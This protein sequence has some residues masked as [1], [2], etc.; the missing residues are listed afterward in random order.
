MSN[1][2]SQ[3][4]KESSIQHALNS[5]RSISKVARDLGI[6]ESTFHN[7]V[8]EYKKAKKLGETPGKQSKESLEEENRR[9]RKELERV[10][11]EREIL[12]KA[13]A[14]FAKEAQPN[15]HG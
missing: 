2:Y 14:Y 10:K 6:N 4:F 9:L 15:T 5:E 12:K 8:Y 3:E 1:K 7:W 13:A 11:Q